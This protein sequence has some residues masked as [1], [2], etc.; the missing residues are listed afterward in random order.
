MVLLLY[1][2]VERTTREDKRLFNTLPLESKYLMWYVWYLW[3]IWYTVRL[4]LTTYNI[5]NA[6]RQSS[7][8]NK[9]IL[10]FVAYKE[11][12]QMVCRNTSYL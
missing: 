2:F 1:D 12:I 4:L 3:Y 9:H 5:Y 11:L 8:T 6:F 10:Y 7:T